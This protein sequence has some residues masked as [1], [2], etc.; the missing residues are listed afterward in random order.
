MHSL[1]TWSENVSVA[2]SRE[3]QQ[4]GVFTSFTSTYRPGWVMLQISVTSHRRQ[5]YL[6]KMRKNI[7]VFVAFLL[8]IINQHSSNIILFEYF[9]SHLFGDTELTFPD[10]HFSPISFKNITLRFLLIHFK[11][12]YEEFVECKHVAELCLYFRFNN[13]QNGKDTNSLGG[14]GVLQ[15]ILCIKSKI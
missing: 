4:F 13:G 9:T 10:I 15:S 12:T 7:F 14:N 1:Q 2:P 11:A 6:N 3:Q 5:K 8:V